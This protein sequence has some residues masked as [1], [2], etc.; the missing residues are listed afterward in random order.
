[1][2]MLSALDLLEARGLP[3][4]SSLLVETETETLDRVQQNDQQSL[5]DMEAT[6]SKAAMPMHSV[7]ELIE[8]QAPANFE[9]QV[10]EPKCDRCMSLQSE[11]AELLDRIMIKQI[12]IQRSR[13]ISNDISRTQ[14]LG[15]SAS[16]KRH[17]PPRRSLRAPKIKHRARGLPMD[18]LTQSSQAGQLTTSTWPDT[19]YTDSFPRPMPSKNR[20]GNPRTNSI[21]GP[22]NPSQT[23]SVFR[24]PCEKMCLV[25][26]SHLLHRTSSSKP[27][28]PWP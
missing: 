1:M 15:H 2:P 14:S 23:S 21:R 26:E 28:P 25:T 18:T 11:E 4:D 8:H 9:L 20:H 6:G 16:P 22:T 3:R 17:S 12:D 27:L 24:V 13:D 19:T 5:Q 10:P 7:S